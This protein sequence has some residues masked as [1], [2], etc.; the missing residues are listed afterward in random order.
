MTKH[1]CNPSTQGTRQEIQK[2][3]ASLGCS[4][5]PSLSFEACFTENHLSLKNSEWKKI[6]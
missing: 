2:F 4:E 5:M 1:P 6:K 3:K